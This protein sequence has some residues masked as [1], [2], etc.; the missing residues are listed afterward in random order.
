MVLEYL[1]DTLLPLK[2]DN[3]DRVH[4][5]P[6]ARNLAGVESF[7]PDLFRKEVHLHV[8]RRARGEKGEGKITPP[9]RAVAAKC[10][11]SVEVGEWSRTVAFAIVERRDTRR[12]WLPVYRSLN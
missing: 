7:H 6:L 10:W 11:T 4:A 1:M 2:P 3:E 12:I 5:G 9:G 8:V